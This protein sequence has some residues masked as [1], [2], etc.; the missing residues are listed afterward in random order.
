[1]EDNQH[2]WIDDHTDKDLEKAG[3][4]ACTKIWYLRANENIFILEKWD[5]ENNTLVGYN[6]CQKDNTKILKYFTKLDKAMDYAINL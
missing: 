5:A 6:L 4:Y 3:H 2:F 1:M